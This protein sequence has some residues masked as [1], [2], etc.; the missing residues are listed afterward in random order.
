M[1]A[2]ASLCRASRPTERGCRDV[3]QRRSGG[4][5]V[6]CSSFVSKCSCSMPGHDCC[7]GWGLHGTVPQSVE[8]E[9]VAVQEAGFC[10]S[11][12]CMMLLDAGSFDTTSSCCAAGAG[13]GRQQSARLQNKL[14]MMPRWRVQP[15]QVQMQQ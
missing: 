12:A 3:N 7:C 5:Q 9:D 8:V 1:L 14:A 4:Q 15:L 11:A 2:H 6:H 13:P 10:S